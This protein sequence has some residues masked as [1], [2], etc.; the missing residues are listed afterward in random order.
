MQISCWVTSIDSVF[1]HCPYC[2]LNP[3]S[4]MCADKNFDSVL[5]SCPAPHDNVGQVIIVKLIVMHCC[6]TGVYCWSGLTRCWWR[7]TQIHRLWML[8]FLFACW[9]QQLQLVS[10]FL[11]YYFSYFSVFLCGNYS[12]SKLPSC[13]NKSS[14]TGGLIDV[15]QRGSTTTATASVTSATEQCWQLTLLLLLLFGFSFIDWLFQSHSGPDRE[16]KRENLSRSLEWKFFVPDAL[17]VIQLHSCRQ[18][19]EGTLWSLHLHS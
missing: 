11:I 19:T 4:S 1:S 17:P 2:C 16:V 6:W 5:T 3:V 12:W 14:I 10:G 18:S 7:S 13:R 15:L 8:R 9:W